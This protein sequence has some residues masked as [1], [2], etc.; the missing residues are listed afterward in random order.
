MRLGLES[1]WLTVTAEKP[2]TLHAQHTLMLV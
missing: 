2:Q 1:L